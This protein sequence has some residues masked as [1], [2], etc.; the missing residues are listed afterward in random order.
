[1]LVPG[2]MGVFVG[3]GTAATL[4]LLLEE[5]AGMAAAELLGLGTTT[6]AELTGAGAA[7]VVGTTTVDGTLGAAGAELGAGNSEVGMA[8]TGQIYGKESQPGSSEKRTEDFGKL[9]VV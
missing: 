1:M 3:T 6:G 8:V 7:E 9:T 2:T 4:L 5:L